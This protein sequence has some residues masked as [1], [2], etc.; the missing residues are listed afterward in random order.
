MAAVAGQTHKHHGTVT[1]TASRNR[2]VRVSLLIASSA[3]DVTPDRT[4]ITQCRA[5]LTEKAV[6]I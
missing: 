5:L 6:S 1:V 4:T 3:V 2:P